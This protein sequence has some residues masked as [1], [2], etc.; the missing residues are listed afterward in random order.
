MTDS[1]SDNFWMLAVYELITGYPRIEPIASWF[2]LL[3]AKS[4]RFLTLIFIQNIDFLFRRKR[5]I[6]EQLK[7]C[8][9]NC[10][11]PEFFTDYHIHHLGNPSGLP[12]ILPK[13]D[14]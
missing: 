6:S 9:E 5:F 12:D 13:I 14:P 10:G 4:N 3:D 8:N 7:K 1:A 2:V 11:L